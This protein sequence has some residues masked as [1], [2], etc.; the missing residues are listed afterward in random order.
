MN[1]T[2]DSCVGCGLCQKVC[3]CKNITMVDKKP[4]WNHSCIGCNACVVYCPKKAILFKTPEAYE[5]LD[6]AITHRLGLP[7][8]RTR[9]HNPHI[10]AKDLISDK[11]EIVE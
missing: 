6:N 10:T 8:K 9:Y 2:S 3:P 11:A 4:Q 7:E 1:S 5:K